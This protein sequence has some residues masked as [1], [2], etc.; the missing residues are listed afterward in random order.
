MNN[1]IPA[2][3]STVSNSF[4]DFSLDIAVNKYNMYSVLLGTTIGAFILQ[5]IYGF[6]NGISFTGNSL[7]YIVIAI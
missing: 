6:I 2:I 3:I 5:I 1:R 7:I 4:C